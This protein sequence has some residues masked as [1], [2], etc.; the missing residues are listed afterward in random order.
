MLCMPFCSTQNMC[1][2]E[3]FEK[4]KHMCSTSK[5]M[6]MYKISHKK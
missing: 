5:I 3:N 2:G 1:G 4:K 6:Y